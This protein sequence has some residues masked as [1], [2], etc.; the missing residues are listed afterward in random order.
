MSKYSL[1]VFPILLKAFEEMSSGWC[2]WSRSSAFL[3]IPAIKLRIIISE[4]KMNRIINTLSGRKYAS[5]MWSPK[6]SLLTWVF[7][8]SHN[9]IIKSF[10]FHFHD[11]FCN[12]H[13]YLFE[14]ILHIISVYRKQFRSFE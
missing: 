10:P 13:G 6:S 2:Q 3:P 1:I 9:L 5:L 12:V 8:N 7:S 11:T 4:M 14:L